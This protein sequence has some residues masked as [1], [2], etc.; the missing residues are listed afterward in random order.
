[1]DSLQELISRGRFILADAPER[2]KTFE[3]V[4]GRRNTAEIA[5]I[6]KR[7][8]NSIRRDLTL[9]SDAGLIQPLIENGQQIKKNGFPIFEK[10]PLARTI[11]VRY[12]STPNR[13]PTKSN[14]ARVPFTNSRKGQTRIPKPLTIP[15]E[16]EILQI[17]NAGEDQFYEFKGQGTDTQK[18]TREIA[19]MLNTYQ[20]GIVFYGIDDAGTIEGSEISQ[21]KFD[22]PLQNSVRNAISPSATIEI[23]TVKVLGSNV[24][25]IRVPPWNRKDIYQYNEKVLIRKGTNV[26]AAKP[27]ELR[28]L[29]SGKHI[30]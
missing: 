23:R 12:F 25:V 15:T 27:D 4:N 20:G 5:E 3:T 26:F 17:A 22:Q 13:L 29:H 7:H 30:T 21:Q 2:L 6:V 9:L 1:M 14:E 11:P 24:I 10:V 16:E 19:A 18:L 28:Q 8:I